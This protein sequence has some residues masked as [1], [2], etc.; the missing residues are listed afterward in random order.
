VIVLPVGKVTAN[1]PGVEIV[2][3]SLDDANSD[4]LPLQVKEGGNFVVHYCGGGGA[5][6]ANSWIGIFAE[7]TPI[8]NM[9]KAHANELSNW[10]Y[11]PGVASPSHC[12]EGA[13]PAELAPNPNY[14]V[15]LFEGAPDGASTP[16]G[17][18]A[19]FRLT[20]ALL[21]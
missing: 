20:P 14:R 6:E 17:S 2:G 18:S 4:G 8:A 16:T 19:A 12:G 3:A 7:G 9:T 11:T 5:T 21:Q 10:L 1:A 15:Y 13:F